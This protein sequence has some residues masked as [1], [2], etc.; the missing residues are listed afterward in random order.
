MIWQFKDEMEK[1]SHWDRENADLLVIFGFVCTGTLEK[2]C[3]T[4]HPP[5]P[6]DSLTFR[7][8]QAEL[9]IEVHKFAGSEERK[10]GEKNPNPNW[11][12]PELLI[13]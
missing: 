10:E 1:A 12:A 5:T 3:F 7:E 6:Y 9:G 4:H 11:E 2:L 8:F 13:L